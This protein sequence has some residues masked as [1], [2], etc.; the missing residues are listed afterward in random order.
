[1]EK[2][3]VLRE[4]LR[5]AGFSAPFHLVVEP[6]EVGTV[7]YLTEEIESI[8]K[9]D[10]AAIKALTGKKFFR[11]VTCAGVDLHS[12]EGDHYRGVDIVRVSYE[13]MVEIDAYR[14]AIPEIKKD[15]L[16][17]GLAAARMMKPGEV[18]LGFDGVSR[19]REGMIYYLGSEL[20]KVC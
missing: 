17:S 3:F 4:E 9:G 7:Y 8:G 5:V 12:S 19:D 2:D 15:Y 13:E 6:L 1:M 14:A 18:D 11:L 20:K 16:E 10:L